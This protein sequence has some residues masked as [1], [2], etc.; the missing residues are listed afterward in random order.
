MGKRQ[1]HHSSSAQVKATKVTGLMDTHVCVGVPVAISG[2]LLSESMEASS[3][4]T[5]SPSTSADAKDLTQP[6]QEFT[7]SGD[8]IA[9]SPSVLEHVD[10]SDVELLPGSFLK[11]D[12]VSLPLPVSLPSV[13]SFTSPSDRLLP[14]ENVSLKDVWLIVS[15]MESALTT[16]LQKVSVF[17]KET[18]GKLS[19][20]E[21]CVSALERAKLSSEKLISSQQSLSAKFVQDLGFLHRQDE[22]KENVARSKNLRFLNFPRTYLSPLILVQKYFKEV[23]LFKDAADVLILR[24]YYLPKGKVI[25]QL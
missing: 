8:S 4:S 11:L 12:P 1:K 19:D 5:V 6:S 17:S 15:R 24:L 3:M 21:A 18:V 25:A 23:L 22:F 9:P 20:H 10:C 14:P 2:S 16:S 13:I 7:V